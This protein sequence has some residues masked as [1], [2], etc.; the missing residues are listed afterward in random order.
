MVDHYVRA[1][2]NAH[3]S[4]WAYFMLIK[5]VLYTVAYT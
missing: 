1:A 5:T 3:S 4:E 2:V